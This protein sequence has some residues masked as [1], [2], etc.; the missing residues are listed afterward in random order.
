VRHR[1]RQVDATGKSVEE[2]AREVALLLPREDQT[3]GSAW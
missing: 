2:V 1:W 3:N